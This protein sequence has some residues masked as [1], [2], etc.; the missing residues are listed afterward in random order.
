HLLV[1]VNYPRAVKSH[2]WEW[3]NTFS[4]LLLESMEIYPEELRPTI[5]HHARS[6]KASLNADRLLQKDLFQ[7][8]QDESKQIENLAENQKFRLGKRIFEKGKKRKIRY[9]C[10]EIQT[11][12]LYTVS[13]SAIAD[14]IFET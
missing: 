3:K 8:A 14:E 12:K 4:Q 2:G 10:K 11:G 13:G 6:P 1:R 9:L 7:I 5:F